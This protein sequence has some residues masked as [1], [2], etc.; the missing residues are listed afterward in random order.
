M[1]DNRDQKNRLISIFGPNNILAAICALKWSTL[2]SKPDLDDKG[3]VVVVISHPG[4][5]DPVLLESKKIIERIT[6]GLG[7][8]RPVL[9]LD[10]Q[11]RSISDPRTPYSWILREFKHLIDLDEISEFYFA[12]DIVGN[13][14]E[15]AMNAFPKAKRITF[16]DA[17]GSIYDKRYHLELASSPNSQPGVSNVKK[18]LPEIIRSVPKRFKHILLSSINI[19]RRQHQADKAVLIL[20]M[21][22]TGKCLD[23]LELSVV[24][25]WLVNKVIQDCNKGLP[26]L[27]QYCKNLVKSTTG[28]RYVFL[29][30]NIA[31]GG[32]ASV[33]SEVKM[34]EEM[35]N[36]N[37]PKGSTIFIKSHPLS[38]L[39][40]EKYLCERLERDYLAII[41]SNEFRRYPIELWDELVKNCEIL[42][43][44]YG[45][46]SLRYLYGINT[47]YAMKYSII[48]Y[49]N[50]YKNAH[51]LYY[52]QLDRLSKWDGNGI[53]WKGHKG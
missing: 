50:S 47:K 23:S 20:P 2:T 3:Q 9:I 39:P 42:S 31:D 1:Q 6:S 33:E 51:D 18:D 22:Q 38:V 52:N 7:W 28:P 4:M 48:E 37:I 17:L 25:K 8:K 26:E 24:P 41:I 45:T 27:V 21:D 16:G 49:W 15:L 19:L 46:I 11:R 35:I 5:P 40:V 34:Y 13:I 43:M 32:F 44:S 12:H 53:L 10:E 30:E 36:I 29:L 14:P